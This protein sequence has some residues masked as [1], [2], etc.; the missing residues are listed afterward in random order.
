[1]AE[2]D[3]ELVHA[4]NRLIDPV[5]RGDP[6]SPLRWTSKAVRKLAE[7]LNAEGHRVAATT[8][9]KLLKGMG[10]SLKA[11]R[12]TLEG[13]QHPD[14]DA[15]FQ[16]I[17]KAVSEEQALGNPT[18][19][20]DTKKKE[21]VG[22]YKNAGR[23]WEPK[24]K[25]VEVDCHDFMGELGRASPYGVY[26]MAHNEGWV[27]VGI[28]ADTAEFAVATVR[29]WWEAVGAQRHARA[30]ELLIT[31]DGGGSNGYQIWLW[32]H[33]LQKLAN[34]LGKPIRVCHLPPGTSK[35]NKIEHRMFSFVT[36]NWRGRPLTDYQ[37]IVELIGSTRTQG[38]L[39]VRCELDQRQYLRDRKLSKAQIAALN[40]TRDEFHG[41]W[42]YTLHPNK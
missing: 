37:T 25:P 21:L 1:V 31:A 35:W 5:T 38:G 20:V 12:K 26:D 30:T 33:E 29:R 28:S 6:E 13:K 8:V 39:T 18:I 23:E 3:S 16:H 42:N 22:N 32:K 40:L 11:N 24:D 41:E 36:M 9:R 2:T 14:R 4:L 34:E 19:S 27:S 10:Y 7:E 17:A 15:Q